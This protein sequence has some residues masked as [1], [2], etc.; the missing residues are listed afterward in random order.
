MQALE[1]LEQQKVNEAQ[2]PWKLDQGPTKSF[3]EIQQEQ[4]KTEIK[5]ENRSS[6]V[7]TPQKV[8]YFFFFFFFFFFFLFLI[9][10]LF[11]ISLFSDPICSKN[12]GQCH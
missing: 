12:L 11:L 10:S 1:Q 5:I 7:T 8:F 2:A 9:F 6:N 4:L 3:L